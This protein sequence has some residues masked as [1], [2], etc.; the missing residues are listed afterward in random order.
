MTSIIITITLFNSPNQLSTL[1]G[2]NTKMHVV[3][4]TLIETFRTMRTSVLF[5]ISMNLQMTAEVPSIIE[6]FTTLRTLCSKFFC[7]FMDG[8]AEKNNKHKSKKVNLLNHLHL[9]SHF[10]HIWH[11]NVCLLKFYDVYYLA[12]GKSFRLQCRQQ[13]CVF[14]LFKSKLGYVTLPHIL[15]L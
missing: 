1:T 3:S 6:N 4:N 5:S 13:M 15:W 12:K 9:L 11:C 10:R 7:T 14:F 8:S 2:M